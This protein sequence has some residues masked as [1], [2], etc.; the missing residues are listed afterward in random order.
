MNYKTPGVYREELVTLPPAVLRTGVPAFLGYSEHQP[1]PPA[2]RTQ[3][4]GLLRLARD[5]A[6]APRPDDEIPPRR[7]TL[8][9]DFQQMFGSPLPG[10]Y[11]GHAVRGFFENGGQVCYVVRLGDRW[12]DDLAERARAL[13]RGLRAIQATSEVDLVCAPDIMAPLTAGGV[14]PVQRT[15]QQGGDAPDELLVMQ[16]FVVQHCYDLGDRFAILDSWFGAD[17]DQVLAQRW[18]LERQVTGSDRCEDVLQAQPR[19]IEAEASP[20]EEGTLPEAVVLPGPRTTRDVPRALRAAEM[21][22][23]DPWLPGSNAALYYPWIKVIDGPVTTAGFVPPCG[24]VAGIISQWDQRVGVHRAPANE[25]VAGALDLERDLTDTDQGR[26]NEGDDEERTGGPS[27]NINALRSFRGRGIRVWGARTLSHDPN[28]KYI[29][30]RRIFLTAVRWIER[31]MAQVVFEPSDQRLWGRIERD[32]TVY[33]NGLY[34]AGAL[35]GAS[36]QEAFYVRCNEHTNPPEL[37][38]QGH[39][40]TEIGL[41][42]ALPNE[43]IVVRLVQSASGAMIEGPSQV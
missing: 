37:R 6:P 40:V 13:C 5:L 20:S 29:S 12:S 26:L 31:N 30:V 22:G 21:R 24:H 8:W 4:L 9:A 3:Q 33:F 11:L 17:V 1:L 16:R 25:V 27:P 18:G 34:R 36:P 10:G 42:P 14:A 19:A 7:L 15:Q 39:V 32:L 41:A 43:F 35:K 23:E 38:D 2:P 28:W